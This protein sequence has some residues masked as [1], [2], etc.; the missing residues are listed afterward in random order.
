MLIVRYSAFFKADQSSGRN[1]AELALSLM[2][3]E[4]NVAPFVDIKVV[5]YTLAE[6]RPSVEALLAHFGFASEI[7]AL[8]EMMP[9]RYQENVAFAN[10]L[11]NLTEVDR[12]CSVRMLT[13]F[14]FL[15]SS[16]HR[17]LIGTDVFFLD[18]PQEIFAF[19]WGP[20]K[21]HS[22]LFMQDLFTFGGAE[23]GI[24]Y[25]HPRS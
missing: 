20:H 24:R 16:S 4:R 9:D 18:C 7:M 21:D 17:L 22:I 11:S 1:Y 23:Y 2:T 5:I 10:S 15:D 6:H 25:Y 19:V 14:E 3:V 13:D 8:D 12:I